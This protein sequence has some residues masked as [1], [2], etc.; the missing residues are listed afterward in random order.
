MGRPSWGS[1]TCCRIVFGA[2]IMVTI[3]GSVTLNADRRHAA[4]PQPDEVFVWQGFRERLT[5]ECF[6][7]SC[8]E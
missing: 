7:W 4:D 8:P 1:H 6:Y 5:T 3:P 2:P